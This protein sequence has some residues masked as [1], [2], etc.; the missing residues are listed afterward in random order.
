MLIQR[1]LLQWHQFI[2][3]KFVIGCKHVDCPSMLRSQ[4]AGMLN[5]VQPALHRCDIK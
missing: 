5:G 4:I 1:G 3:E 2:P